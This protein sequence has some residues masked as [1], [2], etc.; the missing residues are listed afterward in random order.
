MNRKKNF[1]DNL[2]KIDKSKDNDIQI[3]G[4]KRE[5]DSIKEITKEALFFE[6]DKRFL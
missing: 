6:K 5:F 3:K 1:K 2:S 4:V